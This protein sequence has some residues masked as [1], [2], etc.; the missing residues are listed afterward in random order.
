MCL[1]DTGERAATPSCS[2]RRSGVKR[3]LGF[4][5]LLEDARAVA[6][7]AVAAAR[8]GAKVLVIKNTVADCL[9]T[10]RAVENSAA[11]ENAT[12]VL[13]TCNGMA[14]PHHARFARADREALDFA[15]D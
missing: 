1:R 5:P 15:L 14:A 7:I 11:A 8:A 4:F 6:A 13:F 3:A 9:E 2:R 12:A 10:Q